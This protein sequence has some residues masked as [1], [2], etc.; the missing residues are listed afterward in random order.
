MEFDERSLLCAEELFSLHDNYLE[1]DE[2]SLHYGSKRQP[3][4]SIS[5]G[6]SLSPPPSP[7]S[8]SSLSSPSSTSH[9]Q[10]VHS[11]SYGGFLPFS[12]PQGGDDE[13]SIA[14]LQEKHSDYAP[15]KEY[16][17]QITDQARLTH[18]HLAEYRCNA[19][20]WMIKVYRYN[21]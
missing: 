19:A 10:N 7:S 5:A 4:L 17:S 20:R 12:F 18:I 15:Q 2:N 1:N 14:F 3:T 13:L 11:Q 8:S 9:P 16:V 6:I 21:A